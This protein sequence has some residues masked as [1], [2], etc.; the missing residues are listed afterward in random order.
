MS[1]FLRWC[2]LIGCGLAWCLFWFG[3]GALIWYILSLR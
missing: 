2:A 3:L 1:L